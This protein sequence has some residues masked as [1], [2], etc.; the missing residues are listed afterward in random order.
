M[1]VEEW[2][3]PDDERL[4]TGLPRRLEGAAELFDTTYREDLDPTA[5]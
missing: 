4:G 3:R 5:E 2:G 1:R